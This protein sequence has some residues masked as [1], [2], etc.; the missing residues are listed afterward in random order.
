ME[1]VKNPET[2]PI[3][4][5]TTPLQEDSP[6]VCDKNKLDDEERQA[7]QLLEEH[8][9]PAKKAFSLGDI[10]TTQCILCMIII[11]GVVITNI[12][13]PTLVQEF[14][15]LYNKQTQMSSPVGNFISEQTEKYL[16]AGE[17]PS[18]D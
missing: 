18:N 10:F 7:L 13:N 3:E 15:S 2:A 12:M 11:L 14:M 16:L 17:S 6:P 1:E 9:R 5:I 8:D 4:K